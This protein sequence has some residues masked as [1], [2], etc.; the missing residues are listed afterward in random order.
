MSPTT[1]EGTDVNATLRAEAMYT[2]EVVTH[3]ASACR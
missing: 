1:S 3:A 2:I